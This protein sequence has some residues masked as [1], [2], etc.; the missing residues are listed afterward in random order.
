ME[1]ALLIVS[2][3][4]LLGLPSSFVAAA[5][6]DASPD[7]APASE[8]EARPEPEAEARP[9]PETSPPPEANEAPPVPGDRTDRPWLR[10]WGPER[11]MAELGL[12][13]GVLLTSRRA[14]L[15][16][17]TFDLPD[18][19][20][21]PL[22]PAAP[23]FGVRVGY[24][25]VPWFGVEAE[26]GLMPTRAEPR[27]RALLGT[28]RGSLVGQLATR[29]SSWSVTPFVLMGGGVLGVSSEREVVGDDVDASF[30]VGGGVKVFVHR[31]AALRL[32]VRDVIGARRGYKEG[33]SHSPEILL[34]MT[35][36]L[37]RRRAAP[38]RRQAPTP[39]E[40]SRQDLE[41]TSSDAGTPTDTSA[42]QL[43]LR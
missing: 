40:R 20:Y 11:G 30:H 21:R 36:T 8:A 31:Y 38:P 22:A 10:R 34:G 12:Y 27:G 25:S 37:G 2:A 29:R 19:G 42:H 41:P 33:I 35:V 5:E 4:L 16:E 14:E 23:D 9:E 18:Q 15:F 26:A 3:A 39:T 24:F 17:A 6:P 43:H 1:R 32:D 28:L 7:P 13:G